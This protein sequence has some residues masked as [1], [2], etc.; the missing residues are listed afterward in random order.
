MKKRKKKKK[1][2]QLR[3]YFTSLRAKQWSFGL[4]RIV[5]REGNVDDVRDI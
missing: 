2:E 5:G 3:G 1:K 4:E